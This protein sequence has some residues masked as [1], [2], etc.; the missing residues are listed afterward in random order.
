MNK[1]IILMNAGSLWILQ[2]VNYL[3]PFL[4]IPHLVRVLGLDLY[5]DYLFL[6]NVAA[7]VLVL[8]D[9]GLV[10]VLTREISVSRADKERIKFVF[11]S[12]LIWKILLACVGSIL[13]IACVQLLGIRSSV[14]FSLGVYFSV[15]GITFLPVWFFQG[16]EKMIYVTVFSVLSRVIF[17]GAVFLFVRDPSDYSV[18]PFLGVVGVIVSVTCSFLLASRYFGGASCKV[19]L[20]NSITFCGRLGW[21]MF[22]SSAFCGVYLVS[23]SVALQLYR[24][25]EEVAVF[26]VM[27]RVIRAVGFFLMP[28][29]SA[30]FPVFSRSLGRGVVGKTDR[31]AL[32]TAVSGFVMMLVCGLIYFLSDWLCFVLFDKSS[33]EVVVLFRWM[34]LV[35]VFVTVARSLSLNYF[36]VRSKE[37]FLM[38]LY[39]FSALLAVLLGCFIVPDYGLV[40]AVTSVIVVELFGVFVLAFVFIYVRR[41][42]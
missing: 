2:G 32:F 37:T 28:I 10:N 12:V 22:L 29:N 33:D 6:V 3:A 19:N 35:P 21:K 41:K 31:V 7:Y 38:V 17:T 15:V 26:T 24:S 39:L 1:K 40:G 5:G 14:G 42:P 27:D 11:T 30:L 36:L 13:F 23:M 18:L 34:L 25:S 9:F 20:R 8:V 4:V 16:L